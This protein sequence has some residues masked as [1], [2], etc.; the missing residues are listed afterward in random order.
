LT[1]EEKI[2]IERAA[3]Q[4]SA[5]AVIAAYSCGEG[6]LLHGE[7]EII[8][9][10]KELTSLWAFLGNDIFVSRSG[11]KNALEMKPDRICVRDWRGG[12]YEIDYDGKLLAESENENR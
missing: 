8:R 6:Y 11:D 2:K 3:E 7:L 10:S 9:L 1:E 4:L 12:C 5:G